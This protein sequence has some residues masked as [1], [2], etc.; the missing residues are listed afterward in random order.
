MRVTK[1]FDAIYYGGAQRNRL[2]KLDTPL[3]TDWLLPM[4]V[5]GHARLGRDYGFTVDAVSMRGDKIELTALIGKAVTLWILQTDGTYLPHHGYVHTFSRLGSDG[6]LTVYRLEFTSWMHFLHF[7]RDM[8]DWQEQ[9]GEDIISEVFAEHP[10]ARGAYRFDLSRP[11]PR[12]SN[13]VQ[14][15]YDWNFVHRSLEEAGVFGRFEQA[16]NGKSHT[17]VLMDDLYRVPQISQL[18]VPFHRAGLR[19]EVDG[20]SQ[21]MEQ[22][23]IQ[24]AKLTTKSFDYKRPDHPRR[25]GAI[26]SPENPIPTDGEVYDYTGAHT[27]SQ[28]EVGEHQATVRV[29]AWE[30]Q[31]KRFQGV[32]SLR[33]A[34][35]GCWFELT[36]HPVH[37]AGTESD[38][39]FA[40]LAV[41]WSIRNNLPGMDE[42]A[43]FPQALKPR[44]EGVA[45]AN[46][47]V[48]VK[49]SDG[50]AGYFQVE[51]EAQRR[52][53]AFRSPLEHRKPVM[54]LQSAIVAGPQGEEAFTDAL[55]R[56]KVWFPWNRRNERDERASVWVRAAF[57]DAG[58]QRGGHFPLRAGDEVLVGFASGDCDRAVIIGRMHGGAA[59]P[60]WHTNGLLSGFRSKEYSGSGFNQL[61]FDDSTGQNRVHLYSTSA[62]SHL[63]LGYLV[64]QTNNTRGAYLGSGFDLRSN[65]YG[66]VRAAQGLYVTTH[67]KAPNSQPLDAKEARQQLVDAESIVEAL[68]D[69]SEQHGAQSLKDGH[70]AL[71]AF[72]D[73]TQESVAGNAS[74]GRTAGGGTGNVN[75]FGQPV[76]LFGSPAGIGLSSQQSVHVSATQHVN[77]VSGQSTHVATGK[78]LLASVGE[79]LSLF[80]Q[81]AGM[82]LFA[83]KGKVEVQAQSD[84]IEL[85]A[86]KS[87]KILSTTAKVEV[88]A[89][90]GILLASGG[91]YIRIAGGNIEVHAPGTVDIKGAQHAWNGPASMGYPLPSSRPDQPGQLALLHKYFNEEPVK[92]G[93]F[94]VLDANGAV[95]KQG[96]LDAGGHTVVGGLPAGAALVRFGDDPR[97]QDQTPS[98][99]KMPEWPEEPEQD[100]AGGAGADASV[101]GAA[102]GQMGGFLPMAGG[103]ANAGGIGA[104]AGSAMS[105]AAGNMISGA[106]GLATALSAGRAGLMQAA[107]GQGLGLAQQVVSKALPAGAQSV[108]AQGSGISSTAKQAGGMVEGSRGNASMLKSF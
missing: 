23:R 93:A 60:V 15:E 99:F 21:W 25:I 45:N 75:G 91:A 54:Q 11:M 65:A 49:H 20:L 73:A 31:A 106:A 48:V 86:Q 44:I 30:S 38:R 97:Q 64:D 95:L 88:A 1:L 94:S 80:V 40:I 81:N 2:I 83:A 26:T 87:V 24:S 22:Q 32:G 35:P 17:L 92:T 5:Q 9:G 52:R 16:E 58:A 85:T 70:E 34:M 27:W 96:A 61:V 56:V 13:R 71:R 62:D 18:R 41:T 29:E 12:Y 3:G 36:G 107:A 33:N 19:E 50:S 4:Y 66:A 67:Q 77:V 43:D 79:K 39:E 102:Q 8:R 63:H 6:Y 100:A 37:D 59:P 51:I 74:G 69:V 57:P 82:K 10:Q 89:D 14:W 78:S 101:A 55:N 46:G 105:G 98:R 28:R 47:G 103:A 104:L 72:T 42:V 68:S 7:R 84:N 90:Q 76:M 53:T 108:L